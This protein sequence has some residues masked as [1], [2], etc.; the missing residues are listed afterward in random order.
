MHHLNNFTCVLSSFLRFPFWVSPPFM[1]LCQVLRAIVMWK[2]SWFCIPGPLAHHM[3]EDAGPKHYLYSTLK[4]RE[5]NR[6]R[7]NFQVAQEEGSP[8]GTISQ[9]HRMAS[10]YSEGCGGGDGVELEPGLGLASEGSDS[11]HEHP[12]SPHDDRKRPR[13]LHEDVEMGGSGSSGSGTESHGNESHGNES[14]GNES[15]GSSNG[16]GKDSALLESSG[17]NKRWGH[18]KFTEL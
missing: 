5:Q 9:F 10:G 14:H 12:G 7:Q 6:E 17:S 4:G 3:S 1:C 8:C 18:I 13:P 11:S 2:I 15:V 16:N